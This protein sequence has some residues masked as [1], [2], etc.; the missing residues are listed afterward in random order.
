[1]CPNWLDYFPTLFI[2]DY[3]KVARLV[4]EHFA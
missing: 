1:M 3:I 4:G 2:I